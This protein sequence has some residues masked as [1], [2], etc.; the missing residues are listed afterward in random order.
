M[1]VNSLE[2]RE[3]VSIVQKGSWYQVAFFDK[4]ANGGRGL[5]TATL[6]GVKKVHKFCRY[7]NIVHTPGQPYMVTNNLDVNFLLNRG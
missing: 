5:V 6:Q 4:N 3:L 2:P 1:L 7:Q